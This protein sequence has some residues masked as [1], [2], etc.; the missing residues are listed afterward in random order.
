MIFDCQLPDQC[1]PKKI[2]CCDSVWLR[3]YYF[4]FFFY[5]KEPK[6]RAGRAF[7]KKYGAEKFLENQAALPTCH[8][9]FVVFSAQNARANFPAPYF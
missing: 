3:H 1:C 9:G 8:P 7:A 6:K 5:K 4:L 2:F